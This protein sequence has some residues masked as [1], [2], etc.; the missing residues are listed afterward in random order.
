MKE[1]LRAVFAATMAQLDPG[2]AM[3]PG[4]GRLRQRAAAGG[5]FLVLAYGKAARAM[6]NAVLIQLPGARC[7]GL[8]VPP[9]PDDAPLPPFEVIAGGHPVPSAGSLR[10]GRRALELAKSVGR[11]E[12]VLFLAS[13][14]GSALLECA[15]DDAVTL[16][17]LQSLH[18]ALVGSGASI[19]NI[20]LVRKHLSAV[21][22]G[23]LALAAAAASEHVTLAI[24]DVS[25]PGAEWVASAPSL[26]GEPELARC[27]HTLDA[28]GLWPAVPERLRERLRAGQLPSVS[29][30]DYHT[31]H[32]AID[33]ANND[34]ARRCLTR[35][36]RHAGVHVVRDVEPAIA[37]FADDCSWQ[38][39][40]QV[41]VAQLERLRRRWP[42]RRT[43]V[44]AGG[45]LSVPLPSNPGTG[46]RNLQFALGLARWIRGRPI[47]ALSC[48]TDGI[49]GNSPAAGAVVCGTTMARARAG[50]LDVHD[51]LRRFDAFPLLHALGDAVIT[52]PT[53]T[54]VRDL[55]VLVHA[56]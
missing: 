20:N 1:L 51:A 9:E 31:P 41:M 21:K 47:T 18:R 43:A 8:V 24:N 14:G 55:R 28:R 11:D 10:A 4:L 40:A 39:A 22:G 37:P 42:G 26:P 12:T 17:E 2:A 35:A 44:I 33:V 3:A 6:A 5:R 27:L 50:G 30:A 48:G 19:L 36:L 32:T 15:I 13:G 23:R 56:D 46:G 52:G 54:N 7:R 45:E 38:A 34:M 53:G 29:K 49:D 16:T 25:T